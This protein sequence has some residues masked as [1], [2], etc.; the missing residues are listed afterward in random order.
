MRLPALAFLMLSACAVSPDMQG[1]VYELTETTV[2][3]RGA[4]DMNLGSGPA[5][6]TPAMVAQA[7][8]QCPGAKYLSATPSNLHQ[9]DYTFLYLFRCP[10]GPA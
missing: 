4:Y 9:Y 10:H 3:I 1:S 2:T 5:S 7:E 6:P 8:E